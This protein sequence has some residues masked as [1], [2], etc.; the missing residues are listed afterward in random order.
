[1]TT[2]RLGHWLMLIPHEPKGAP[3]IILFGYID[4]LEENPVRFGLAYGDGHGKL[5][6]S[7]ALFYRVSTTLA[8]REVDGTIWELGLM[9]PRSTV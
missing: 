9:L 6:G 2:L 7:G 5:E 1:M 4:W 3:G 8:K